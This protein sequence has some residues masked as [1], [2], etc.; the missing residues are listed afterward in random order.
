M[1]DVFDSESH[2]GLVYQALVSAPR[3][4]VDA[5]AKRTLLSE[6]AIRD[7]LTEL[8]QFDAVTPVD[9]TKEVWEARRPDLVAAEAM[10]QFGVWRAQLLEAEERLTTAFRYARYEETSALDFEILQGSD[11]FFERFKQL[12]PKA[13]SHV[14]GIDRPPYYWEPDEIHRQERMQI[15]QMAAGITYRTIYQESE[16]DSPVRNASMAR[17]VASGENARVLARPPIKMTIIDC[18]VGVVALDPPAGAEGSLSTLLVRRSTLLDAFC[19]IFESLWSLAVPVN[20]DRQNQELSKR[21]REILTLMA[22]GAG[23]DAIARR[24]GVSRR[25][26]VRHIGRLLEHLGSTTRFQAGAQAARRGWL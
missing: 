3:S 13:R 17:S 2:H 25:T 14:W 22:S 26:I 21:E 4:T 20:L 8:Q 24:L 12:Q 10:R 18:E 15:E 5:L 16:S 9:S 1:F 6:S 23:D 7:S 19:N 11:A